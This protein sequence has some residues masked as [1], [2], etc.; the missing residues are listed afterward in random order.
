MKTR[1]ASR[2]APTSLQSAHFV[3]PSF[4]FLLGFLFL[5]LF[6]Q[7]RLLRLCYRLQFQKRIAERSVGRYVTGIRYPAAIVHPC[8]QPLEKEDK[9]KHTNSECNSD[10]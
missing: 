1:V 4:I 3:R 5:L 2:P 10:L 6:Q 8:E 7:V 9:Q